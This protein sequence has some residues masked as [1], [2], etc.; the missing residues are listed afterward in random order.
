MGLFDRFKHNAAAP[1]PTAYQ[2][3][4][5]RDE[6]LARD[7][8]VFG[9]FGALAPNAPPELAEAAQPVEVRY[10]KT[11]IADPPAFARRVLEIAKHGGWA[12]C[13][14]MRLLRSLVDE[15]LCGPAFNE[16]CEHGFAFLRSRNINFLHLSR[17]E[18]EWWVT[19]HPGE[20]YLTPRQLPPG[21]TRVTPLQPGE[22][23]RVANMGP[24]N[25]ND[26]YVYAADG[27]FHA[28]ILHT[29]ES[30]E[31]ATQY[32]W[33]SHKDLFQLYVRVG[34]A[35]RSEPPWCDPEMARFCLLDPPDFRP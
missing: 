22:R 18:I 8:Y 27:A 34:E 31:S 29:G 6:Q 21:E 9:R 5:S 1:G 3:Q 14:G 15:K 26:I 10:Y 25:N 30:W 11:A 7:L 12:A 19:H 35:F 24:P 4:S 17:N 16:V 13:G 32:H 20:D 2:Q 23:R 28:V 33:F